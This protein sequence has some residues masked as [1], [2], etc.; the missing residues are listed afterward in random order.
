MSRIIHKIVV[1]FVTFE[2]DLSHDMPEAVHDGK[3]VN[4]IRENP[5]AVYGENSV[6]AVAIQWCQAAAC[7]AVIVIVNVGGI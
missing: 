2:R 1:E 3:F 7:T 5:V 4:I 6:G